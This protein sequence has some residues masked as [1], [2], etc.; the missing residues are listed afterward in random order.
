MNSIKNLERLQLLHF[1]IKMEQTGSPMELADKLRVGER[2]AYLLLE[3]LKDYKAKI[4][5]DRSRKTYFYKND[6][7]LEVSISVAVSNG[8][9]ITH[10]F[11]GSYFV[12]G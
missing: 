3:Q 10:L 12:K 5:Y 9:Q 6:F 11:D 1:L 7:E 2:T 4:A 8:G